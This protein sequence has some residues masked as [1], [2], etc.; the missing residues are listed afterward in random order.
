MQIPCFFSF[1]RRKGNKGEKCLQKRPNS[2]SFIQLYWFSSACG[3]AQWSTLYIGQTSNAS[4]QIHIFTVV[5]LNIC[6]HIPF[7]HILFYCSLRYYKN[8][9]RAGEKKSWHLP[10]SPSAFCN[11]SSSLCEPYRFLVLM[12]LRC[13]WRKM[14]WSET[15]L[16]QSMQM[17][18]VGAG[19]ARAPPLA[20]QT[21]ALAGRDQNGSSDLYWPTLLSVP[22]FQVQIYIQ[23]YTQKKDIN[24]SV[25]LKRG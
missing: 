20:P 3:V 22:F 13:A 11:L 1:C 25:K 2:D 7:S 9:T 17:L 8:K 12:L 21:A 14:L 10:S 4:S 16:Y 5:H 23:T 24:S 15:D 19:A 6:K 18:D